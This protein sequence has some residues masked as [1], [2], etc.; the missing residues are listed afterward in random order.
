VLSP[1]TGDTFSSD[2]VTVRFTVRTPSGAPALSIHITVDGNPVPGGQKSIHI[3]STDGQQISST[4]SLPRADCSLRIVADDR[5]SSSEPAIVRLRWQSGADTAIEKPDLYILAVGVAAYPLPIPSLNYSAKDASDF[6]SA[7]VAQKGLLYGNVT[8]KLLTDQQATRRGILDGLQWIEKQATQYD[9]AMI[10]FSGHGVD[11]T[12]GNYYFAP[13]DAD[14]SDIRSTGVRFTDIDETVQTMACK[15]LFFIDTCH[16]GNVLG[17]ARLKGFDIDA[18]VNELSSAENGAVVFASSTG[19]Q[20]SIEDSSWGNG[21]F[22]KALVEGINGSADKGSGR[23][24]WE[25]LSQYVSERVKVL[26]N[27]EQT[28]TTTTPTTVPDF[29]IAIDK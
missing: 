28:P 5:Y 27:G 19:R 10:F 3:V 8:C 25:S 13:V 2:T 14:V 1:A 26:T 15:T 16:A 22:T 6:T 29:P 23:I 21:A 20:E 11:D 18:A 12:K 17:T 24:T 9:V 4:V 7:M